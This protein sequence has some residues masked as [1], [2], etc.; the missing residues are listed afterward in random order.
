MS[1]A[2]SE[3][4]PQDLLHRSSF[5]QFI[6]Q[7]VQIAYFLHQWIFDFLYAHTAH[8][9]FDKCAI[10]VNAWRL[11]EEGFKIVSL[12]DLLLQSSVVIARQPANDLVDFFLSAILA[13]RFLNIQRIDLRKWHRENSIH[14]SLL[15][16]SCL[17]ADFL[18]AELDH[19]LNQREW[20]W[21]IQWKLN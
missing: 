20:N 12:F 10:R 15:S 5:C 14:L 4:L 6:N 16:L 18:H 3:L 11:S 13:F 1:E 2:Y 9:A 8:Y 17:L 19:F 7:L 21:S